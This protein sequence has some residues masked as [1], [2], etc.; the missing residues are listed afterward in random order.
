MFKLIRISTEA[1]FIVAIVSLATIAWVLI[2][3]GAVL[4]PLAAIV[5]ALYLIIRHRPCGCHECKSIRKGIPAP[6]RK[7]WPPPVMSEAQ[8]EVYDWQ[9][10]YDKS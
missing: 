10:R 2:E 3:Y 4:L 8:R 6:M 9:E 1:A 7:P 5:T